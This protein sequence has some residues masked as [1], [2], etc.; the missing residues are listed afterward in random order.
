MASPTKSRPQT[1]KL[2][3][4]QAEMLERAREAAKE[5]CGHPYPDLPFLTDADAALA[6]ERRK[7]F[8]DG[9]GVWPEVKPGKVASEDAV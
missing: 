6:A 2:I 9:G 8:V 3:W 1:R 5:Q 4:Y 7:R